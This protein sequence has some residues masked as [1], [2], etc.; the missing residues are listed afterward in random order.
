MH[1]PRR[2]LSD[3]KVATAEIEALTQ[4]IDALLQ[5]EID[6]LLLPLRR[7]NPTLWLRYQE[8]RAVFDYPGVR[9]REQPQQTAAAAT[10]TATGIATAATTTTLAAAA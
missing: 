4:Q 5:D 10:A 7:T 2:V 3:R 8:A 1:E 6:P 9:R